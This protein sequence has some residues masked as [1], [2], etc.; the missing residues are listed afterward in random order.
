MDDTLKKLLLDYE[1]A[2]EDLGNYLVDHEPND[3]H[4]LFKVADSFWA[5]A[6]E[7]RAE[8]SGRAR[9]LQRKC[10]KFAEMFKID[11]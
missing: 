10:C 5:L 1:K 4:I 2:A 9:A 6:K 7:W 11:F 3:D 8:N